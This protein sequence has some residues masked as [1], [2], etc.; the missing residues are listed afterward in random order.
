MVVTWW[1]VALLHSVC[2]RRRVTRA[3]DSGTKGLG[4]SPCCWSPG[5]GHRALDKLLPPA[6]MGNKC[7]AEL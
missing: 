5:A 7:N 3:T 1:T 6:V 4:F 2:K